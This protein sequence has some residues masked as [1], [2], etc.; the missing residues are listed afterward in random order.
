MD[1]FERID[2][3]IL[4]VENV[5]GAVIKRHHTMYAHLELQ[6]PTNIPTNTDVQLTIRLIRWDNKELIVDEDR[7]I[8]VLVE[9]VTA[10]NTLTVA[11]VGMVVLQF[12]DPGVYLVEV[13]HPLLTST[14]LEVTVS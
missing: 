11:G 1:H 2:H 12:A 6:S 9:G 5:E 4:S 3:E 13:V 8:D 10:A 14:S 7:T